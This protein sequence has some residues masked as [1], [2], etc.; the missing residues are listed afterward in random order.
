QSCAVLEPFGPITGNRGDFASRADNPNAMVIAVGLIDR[1]AR[2]HDQSGWI[3]EARVG[4]AA[5]RKAALPIAG[6]SGHRTI[7]FDAT[8]GMIVLIRYIESA[9]S[10]NL[11]IVGLIELGLVALSVREAGFAV[12]CQ[13]R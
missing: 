6:D 9:V 7:R 12:A 5:V 3:V 10:S 4:A 11:D 2:A 13:C 1:F 8:N